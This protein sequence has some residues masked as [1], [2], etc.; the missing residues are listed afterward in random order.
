[1]ALLTVTARG[2]VTLDKDV[3]QHIGVKPGDKIE[4]LLLPDAIGVVKAGQ[5][6]CAISGF[7]GLLAG[8][9]QKIARLDEIA[10]AAANGWAGKK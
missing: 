2:Q 10:N 1:M 9:T 6:E 3:L 4:V 7:I 5:P 8:R